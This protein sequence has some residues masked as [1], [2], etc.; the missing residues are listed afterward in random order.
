MNRILVS[1]GLRL[2][3]MGGM[4]VLVLFSWEFY[5]FCMLDDAVT[6]GFLSLLLSL[7]DFGFGSFWF[8]SLWIIGS[9]YESEIFVTI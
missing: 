1:L 4:R 9:K 8:F 3:W 7:W 6:F 2:G 5:L